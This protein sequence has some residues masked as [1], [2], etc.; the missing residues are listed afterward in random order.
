MDNET[1]LDIRPWIGRKFEDV[2]Y[3]VTQMILGHGYFRKYM[4]R[5]GKTA[6]FCCLYEEGI[7]IEDAERTVFKCARWQSYRSVL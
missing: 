5:R 3:Y 1:L 4:H 6:S 2:N 7:V